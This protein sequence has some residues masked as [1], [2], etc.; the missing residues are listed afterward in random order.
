MISKNIIEFKDKFI[1]PSEYVNN[2]EDYDANIARGE[3]TPTIYNEIQQEVDKMMEME[4]KNLRT[5]FRNGKKDTRLPK[6]LN[7]TIK[8]K[9]GPGEKG[10]LKL[11]SQDILFDA[12]KNGTVRKIVKKDLEDLICD[13]NYVAHTAQLIDDKLIDIPLFYTKQL[14][15]EYCIIPLGSSHTRQ[16]ALNPQVNSFLFFGPPGCGKSHAA[17]SVASH[18]NS[19][20][21]DL[22]PKNV[23]GKTQTKAELNELFAK[24]FRSARL[25][26]PA[27]IYFEEA[28]QIFIQA[29]RGV[30]KNADAVKLKKL[31]LAYKA[32]VMTHHRIIFIGCTNKGWMMNVKDMNKMFDMKFHFAMPSFSDRYK[33]W[34]HFLTKKLEREYDIEYDV[35]ANMTQGMTSEGVFM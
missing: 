1:V 18:T 30:V 8:E 22:S 35:L 28:E 23:K 24:A 6:P 9:P 12:I 7:N 16:Y 20:F 25:F 34:K 26:G 2:K 14:I 31:L 33:I 17:K 29:K 19:L 32:L 11:P 10:L 21:I 3:I 5:I 4:I 13:F 27:V 15:K